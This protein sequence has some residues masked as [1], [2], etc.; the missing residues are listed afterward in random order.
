M[1]NK[2]IYSIIGIL[3]IIIVLLLQQNISLN[4]SISKSKYMPIIITVIPSSTET[5]TKTIN[6][7]KT[8]TPTL[9]LGEIQ[10]ETSEPT[11]CYESAKTQFDLNNCAIADLNKEDSLLKS[12]I[13]DIK[14]ILLADEY[15]KLLV[16]QKEWE[17]YKEENC[18]WEASFWEGGSVE[19]MSFAQCLAQEDKQ[20]INEIIKFVCNMVQGPDCS[21]IY[22]YKQ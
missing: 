6:P 20:R 11:D 15:S 4:K 5:F 9:S 1:N 14:K 16:T 19:P 13:S 22:V 8:K 12:L 7:T 21:V 18:D 3:S 17:L 10:T 2:I